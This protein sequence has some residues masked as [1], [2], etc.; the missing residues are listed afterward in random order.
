[1]T[2]LFKQIVFCN[3]SSSLTTPGVTMTNLVTGTVFDQYCPLSQLGVQAMPG[4]KLYINGNS[5]P[6]IVGFTGVLSL[7]LSMG[8][9][10]TSLRFDQ[11]SIKDINDNIQSILIVDMAYI[12]G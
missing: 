10:I 4:T 6:I 8:G 12:G 5:N 3:A 7:D 9:E 2:Q 1:M 11:Q